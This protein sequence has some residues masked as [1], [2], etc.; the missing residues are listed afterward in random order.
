MR[1]HLFKAP[2]GRTDTGEGRPYHGF[3]HVCGFVVEGVLLHPAAVSP[4]SEGGVGPRFS[5]AALANQEEHTV[6]KSFSSF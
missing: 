3:S 2:L 1:V 5:S 6:S 4:G